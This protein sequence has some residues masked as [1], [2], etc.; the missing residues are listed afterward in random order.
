MDASTPI[1]PVSASPGPLSVITVVRNDIEGLKL[2]IS[3]VHRL[4]ARTQVEHIVVD[5][6][7]DDRIKRHLEA[8]GDDAE[9]PT[10]WVSEPDRGIYDAMNKGLRLAR[11]AYALFM[12]AGDVFSELFDWSRVAGLL[13]TDSRVLLGYTIERFGSDRY[14]SPGAGKESNVFAAPG[15]QATFYP[16]RFYATERYRLDVSIGG[17]GD[18]SR[19]A[20]EA[21]GGLFVPVI[22]A[23][24]ALGGVSSSYGSLTVV[25]R[26]L[27]EVDSTKERL[28]LLVKTALWRVMPR[29]YFYRMLAAGKY[30][31]LDGS[32]SPTLLRGPLRHDRQ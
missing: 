6:S 15:H 5:G 20:L 32:D 18:Y 3:S 24:F 1:S 7:G 27:A 14:L 29:K 8:L 19:R 2:T 21:C 23:E 17:D 31:R 12:N 11:H 10:R 9:V 13:R 26:R 4:G 28:K 25:R 22:V 30:T 16:R